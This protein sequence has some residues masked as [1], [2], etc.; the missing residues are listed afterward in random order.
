MSK[1]EIFFKR[2]PAISLILFLLLSIILIDL[3]AG[4]VFIPSDNNSFRCKHPFYHHGLKPNC[5]SSTTWNG[6]D[7]YSFYTN[8][9]GLRDAYVRE[10]P[11]IY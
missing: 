7:Y 10:I 9:L 11:T 5:Q 4:M 2:Y 3:I 1:K 8:S 6:T